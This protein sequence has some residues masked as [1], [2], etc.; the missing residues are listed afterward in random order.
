M[1]RA[2]PRLALLAAVL[3]VGATLALRSGGVA[4]VQRHVGEWDA[5]SGSGLRATQSLLRRY[6]ATMAEASKVLAWRDSDPSVAADASWQASSAR[7]SEELQAEY[8]DA[9]A[10]APA[11]EDGDAHACIVEALRLTSDGYAMLGVGA[12]ADGHHAYYLGSHGNWD[13]NLG[14]SK[15]SECKRLLA[16]VGRQVDVSSVA[17]AEL[18]R[19]RRLLR[20]V[21]NEAVA[22]V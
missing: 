4:A 21:R 14:T 15:M 7:V 8:R 13:L 19:V 18:G 16:A 10:M 6:D 17:L 2:S 22:A 5:G 12:Q 1:P 20:P 11:A 9:V 3:V